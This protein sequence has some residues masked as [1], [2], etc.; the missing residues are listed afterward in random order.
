MTE[1]HRPH[2]QQARHVLNHG[3]AP[4]RSADPGVR[5]EQH[6]RYYIPII[7]GQCC[8]YVHYVPLPLE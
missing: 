8:G 7:L 4:R 5:S 1:V 3:R 6:Y 2:E